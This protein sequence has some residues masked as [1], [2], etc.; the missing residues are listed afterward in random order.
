MKSSYYDHKN[1]KLVAEPIKFVSVYR[2]SVL[3]FF[4]ILKED[5]HIAGLSSILDEYSSRST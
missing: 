5:K 4:L 1:N 3:D 2:L